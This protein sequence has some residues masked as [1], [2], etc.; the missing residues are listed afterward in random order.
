VVLVYFRFGSVFP[1]W[2]VYNGLV[3]TLFLLFLSFDVACCV[4]FLYVCVVAVCSLSL[5]AVWLLWYIGCGS[6]GALSIVLCWGERMKWPCLVYVGWHYLCRYWWVPY[7][8][9]CG[10]VNV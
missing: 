9:F 5:V 10:G 3:L 7:R 4:I 8:S 1:I 2:C 6:V